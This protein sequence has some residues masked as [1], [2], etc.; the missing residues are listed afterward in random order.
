MAGYLQLWVM[1]TKQNLIYHL[2]P[3][4]LGQEYWHSLS[5]LPS[6]AWAGTIKIKQRYKMASN[7]KAW[8]K[9][10]CRLYNQNTRSDPSLMRK[11][12]NNLSPKGGML[13][14]LNCNN[15]VLLCKTAKIM[16]LDNVPLL[17]FYLFIYIVRLI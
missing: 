16:L 6:A 3:W 15:M 10:L 2:T 9:L 11:Q 4:G 12:Q 7:A 8:G 17:I 1:R 13:G 14:K 5:Y